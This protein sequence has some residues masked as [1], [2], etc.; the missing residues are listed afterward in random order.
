VAAL[1]LLL[2]LPVALMG[3][4]LPVVFHELR[5]EAENAGG[6]SGRLL[7]WNAAG[8]LAGSLLGGI[9]LYGVFDLSRIYLLAPLI[10]AA[11]ALIAA[12]PL[13]RFFPDGRRAALPARPRRDDRTPRIP[14]GRVRGGGVPHPHTPAFHLRRRGR[15]QP[16]LRHR[17]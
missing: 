14:A 15:L 2:A 7:A 16:G 13:T 9:V 10:A 1:L 5:P 11:G 17:L 3:M 8:C 6:I 12:G 4:T